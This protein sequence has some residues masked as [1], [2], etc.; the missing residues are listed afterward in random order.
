MAYRDL[1]AAEAGE[2][3][4][5]RFATELGGPD[6]PRLDV[7]LALIAAH[8]RPGVDPDAL[9]ARLDGLAADVEAPTTAGL[10]RWFGDAG[11]TGDRQTYA[12]VDNSL[13]DRVLDRRLGIPITLSIVLAEVGRRLGVELVG[14]SMPGHFL[15]REGDHTDRFVD[16]FAGG[17]RLDATGARQVFDRLQDGRLG[18][19]PS[20]LA[21][22]NPEAVVI[23]VLE[24]LVAA[25]SR[26][27][28]LAAV[29]ATLELRARVPSAGPDELRRLAAAVAAAGR[30]DVAA[31]QLEDLAAGLEANAP[32]AEAA[33]L[34]A[35]RLRARMN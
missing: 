22:A 11:F 16:A 7:A 14:V 17:A 30:Y 4:A 13:L 10:L 2:G 5:D 27:R 3:V 8:G 23:R 24:N 28:A 34:D 21:P 6:A 25:R 12:A 26:R 15:L 20:F 18:F 1:M 9:L 29:A 19:H 35:R 32:E 33:L 31:R